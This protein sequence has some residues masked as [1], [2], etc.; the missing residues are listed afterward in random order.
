MILSFFGFVHYYRCHCHQKSRGY[1]AICHLC[2]LICEKFKYSILLVRSVIEILKN[3]LISNAIY[4]LLTSIFEESNILYSVFFSQFRIVSC[5]TFRIFRNFAATVDYFKIV[6]PNQSLWRK[7]LKTVFG[8]F[9][10]ENCSSAAKTAD[11]D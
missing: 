1:L 7:I 4:D 9:P 5:T 10:P 11:L 8:I 3:S 2:T 6:F